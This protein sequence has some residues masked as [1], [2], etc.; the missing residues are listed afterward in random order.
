MV[1][2]NNRI[3]GNGISFSDDRVGL[4]IH[5]LEGGRYVR[6]FGSADRT[7]RRDQYF[8]MFREIASAGNGRFWTV[9]PN[10][11]LIELWDTLGTKHA[12]I[13]G[14]P[15]GDWFRGWYEH[16]PFSFD[17]KPQASLIDVVETG[18]LLI[19][20]AQVP[21]S[22]WKDNIVWK[23]RMGERYVAER[24]RGAAFDTRFDL[25]DAQSLRFL[26]SAV[27]EEYF[28]LFVGSEQLGQPEEASDGREFMRI[29]DFEMRSVSGFR[30][31]NLLP[32]RTPTPG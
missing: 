8:R 26:G 2:P 15:S 12:S 23:E 18:G 3:V 1:L 10:R 11:Y 27:A 29:W 31:I 30:R 7:Y 21:G 22:D 5:L 19:V 32:N 4:P 24:V 13:D 6:S 17:E 25:Y 28:L 20:L 16:T 14:E 9:P